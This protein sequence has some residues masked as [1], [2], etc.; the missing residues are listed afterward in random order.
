MSREMPRL[1]VEPASPPSDSV[2]PRTTA[3]AAG[4]GPEPETRTRDRRSTSAQ[5]TYRWRQ[6]PQRDF[7]ET[8]SRFATA[9]SKVAPYTLRPSIGRLRTR[10]SAVRHGSGMRPTVG[11]PCSFAG[12]DP[13]ATINLRP[14]Y[15]T[16]EHLEP[17]T[18]PPQDSL[19]LNHL[20]HT[21]EARPEL[22]YQY[23]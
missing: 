1:S 10:A 20:G 5:R 14:P 7:A 17:S 22:G 23:E 21:E 4:R 12:S 9:A 16:P 8:F 11:F 15:Q 19:R 6:S 18:M 2:S 3:V 13:Q